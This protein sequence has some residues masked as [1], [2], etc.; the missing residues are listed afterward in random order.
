MDNVIPIEFRLQEVEIKD[1][2]LFFLFESSR[3][4]EDINVL[5]INRRTKEEMHI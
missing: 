3:F 4:F 2:Q 1:A 5:V